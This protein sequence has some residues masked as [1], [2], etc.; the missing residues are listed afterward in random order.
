MQNTSMHRPM[1]TPAI[2]SRPIRQ[3]FGAGEGRTLSVV[4]DIARK[5]PMTISSTISSGV[6]TAWPGH[7]QPGDQKQQR[8]DLLRDRSKV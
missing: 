5:S 4:N 7:Q 8:D 3:T 2:V 6:S 1:M